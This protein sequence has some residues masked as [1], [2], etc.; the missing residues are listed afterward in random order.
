MT[1]AS[2][3]CGRRSTQRTDA[4]A[5]HSDHG[6]VQ[7]GPTTIRSKRKGVAHA[8]YRIAIELVDVRNGSVLEAYDS[9]L[10]YA[11]SYLNEHFEE[12]GRNMA[13]ML[14]T[15]GQRRARRVAAAKK[16]RK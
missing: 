11:D 14:D 10:K 8:E 5:D 15:L 6:C 7:I 3:K 12:T 9:P 4:T 13:C 2:S 1:P 16:G